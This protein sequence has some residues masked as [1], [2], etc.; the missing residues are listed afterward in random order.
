MFLFS[1]CPA[2]C[3]VPPTNTRVPVKCARHFCQEL[4]IQQIRLTSFCFLGAYIV[5]EEAI[6]KKSNKMSHVVYT[7]GSQIFWSQDTFTNLLRTPKSFCL[8]GL[9]ILIFTRL[10]IKTERFKR[11]FIHLKISIT[12]PLC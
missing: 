3:H 5:V 11:L 12:N 4:E 6:N 7:S 1:I 2:I 9:Y 10:E 8:C